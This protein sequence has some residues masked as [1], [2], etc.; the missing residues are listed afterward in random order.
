MSRL[1]VQINMDNLKD[2]RAWPQVVEFF[3]NHVVD[4]SLSGL[5]DA[6]CLLDQTRRLLEVVSLPGV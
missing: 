4:L 2:L 6:H 1:I 3:H 5:V